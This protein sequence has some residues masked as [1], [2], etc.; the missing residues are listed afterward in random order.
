MRRLVRPDVGLGLYLS[1]HIVE[2]HGGRI[3]VQSTP[4]EGSTFSVVL[5]LA[6]A[7]QEKTSKGNIRENTHQP[8]FNHHGGLS[9]EV[10]YYQH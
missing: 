7:M 4:G 8:F 3:E 5:P 1:R 2:Q 9:H 6:S 10:W